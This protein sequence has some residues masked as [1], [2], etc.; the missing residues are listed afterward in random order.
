MVARQRHERKLWQAQR[1]KTRDAI[2][3]ARASTQATQAKQLTVEELQRRIDDLST[4]EAIIVSQEDVLDEKEIQLLES[5]Q[6]SLATL[7]YIVLLKKEIENR[8]KTLIKAQ[9]EVQ[10]QLQMIAAESP[11]EKKVQI[12]KRLKEYNDYVVRTQSQLKIS[13]E[14]LV[15]EKQKL[16]EK[17]TRVIETLAERE[18]AR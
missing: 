7:Q 11:E 3:Q 2:E 6:Q 17:L 13:E 15:K 10:V 16:N 4:R 9:Q 8:E 5:E 18:R 14:L 1:D 12:N